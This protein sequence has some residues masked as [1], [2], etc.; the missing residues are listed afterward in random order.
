MV[1]LLLFS[2]RRRSSGVIHKKL[3]C[4]LAG[5]PKFYLHY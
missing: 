4:I 3:T 1:S 5:T 2:V